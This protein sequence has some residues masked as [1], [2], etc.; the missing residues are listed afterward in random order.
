M[1]GWKRGDIHATHFVHPPEVCLVLASVALDAA[2]TCRRRQA[3]VSNWDNSTGL[4]VPGNSAQPLSPHYKDLAA[5]WG[6]GKYFP[7]AF[8]RTKVEE[9]TAHR[10]RLQPVRNVGLPE[11]GTL[12]DN[13]TMG[14]HARQRTFDARQLPD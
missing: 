12:A 11:R 14:V 8:S 13:G 3:D 2:M 9:V 7:L 10:L 6:E 5:H 1:N 4:S